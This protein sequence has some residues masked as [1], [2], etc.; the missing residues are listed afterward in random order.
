MLSMLHMSYILRVNPFHYNYLNTLEKTNEAMVLLFSVSFMSMTG[1]EGKNDGLYMV[2]NARKTLRTVL[3]FT[4]CI[5]ACLN[6][7]IMIYCQMRK[8]SMAF[9][10]WAV[11]KFPKYLDTYKYI[12]N[13][14][15]T[16]KTFRKLVY[17][18]FRKL[19]KLKKSY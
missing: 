8:D 10:H 3:R 4:L 19:F 14:T 18:T 15:L 1:I 12:Q 7:T 17:K 5:F 13:N 9:N 2:P 6:V 16:I 11:R